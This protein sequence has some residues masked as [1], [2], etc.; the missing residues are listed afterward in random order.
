MPFAI[1]I[2]IIARTKLTA[3]EIVEIE[4]AALGCSQFYY[5]FSIRFAMATIS[6][7][8]FFLSFVFRH[9]QIVCE[10]KRICKYVAM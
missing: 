8:A 9:F 4:F 7:G 2:T 3:R 10:L 5:L 1:L 6:I